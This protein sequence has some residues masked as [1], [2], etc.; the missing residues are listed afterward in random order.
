MSAELKRQ[1]QIIEA[2]KLRDRGPSGDAP[3][4][5][6]TGSLA[7]SA[8]LEKEEFSVAELVS[9]LESLSPDTRLLGARQAASL[10]GRK[11]SRIWL[12]VDAR[13]DGIDYTDGIAAG[14]VIVLIKTMDIDPAAKISR[15]RL[16][17]LRSGG[18]GM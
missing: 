17:S 2:L 12:P 6:I 16:L 11:S 9:L 3:F 4:G 8:F 18:A 15:E 7:A 10:I 5:G 13:L 14:E 1:Q